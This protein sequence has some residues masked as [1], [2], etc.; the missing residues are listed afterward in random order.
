M[1]PL[2]FHW[3]ATSHLHQP[4]GKQRQQKQCYS[5]LELPEKTKKHLT[6]LSSFDVD[7]T[8]LCDLR[9]ARLLIRT[10]V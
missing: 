6:S 5:V 1:C 3:F 10:A 7:K 2:A 8:A 4:I 9:P